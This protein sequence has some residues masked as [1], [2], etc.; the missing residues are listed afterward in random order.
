MLTVS[1]EEI[2][3]RN[4]KKVSRR[5]AVWCGDEILEMNRA[6]KHCGSDDTYR[7]DWCE[8]CGEEHPAEE[9]EYFECDYMD[10]GVNICPKCKEEVYGY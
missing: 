8:C 2:V 7:V 9:I 1:F 3:C 4:C 6:C 5:P 10:E